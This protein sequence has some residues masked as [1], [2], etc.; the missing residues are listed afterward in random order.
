[1]HGRHAGH[2]LERDA[3]RSQGL[4]A[5]DTIAGSV[6]LQRAL[7]AVGSG[8]FSGAEPDRFRDIVDVLTSYDHFLVTADFDAYAAA[9]RQVA[10]LWH[11][12]R[13]WWRASA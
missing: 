10:T 5:R 11:D 9:Q 4:D 2:N 3:R 8:L 6:D 12:Q 13:A 7:D 1:M